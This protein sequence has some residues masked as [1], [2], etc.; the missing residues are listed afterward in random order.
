MTGN[1]RAPGAADPLHDDN[2]PRPG[3]GVDPKLAYLD[4]AEPDDTPPDEDV[5][6]T[7]VAPFQV[8]HGGVVYGSGAIVVVPARIAADWI[9]HGWVTRVPAEAGTSS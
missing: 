5:T 4:P 8:S 7:V 2:D 3:L 9:L 6:V 1:H